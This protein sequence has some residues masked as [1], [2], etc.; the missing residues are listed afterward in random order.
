ME[1]YKRSLNYQLLA[2]S[3][4]KTWG[5]V[6]NALPNIELFIVYKP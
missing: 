6:T 5:G 3:G 2:S 1:H 4:D